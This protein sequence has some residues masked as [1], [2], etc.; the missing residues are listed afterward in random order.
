MHK[1]CTS[2]RESRQRLTGLTPRPRER[3]FSGRAQPGEAKPPALL[4]GNGAVCEHM[5]N[6]DGHRSSSPPVEIIPGLA[7]AR[8]RAHEAAGPAHVLFA[9]QV[10]AQLDGPV[11]WMR[12]NWALDRLMGDGLCH[13]MQPGRLVLARART[14]PE[15]FWTAEEALRTGLVPLV[16]IELPEVP[17]LTAVRRLNLAAETGGA[18]VAPQPAP[19]ALLLTPGAGGAPG[20]ETRWHRGPLPGWAR[21][22]Q[23]PRWRL[24]RTRAR[25]APE[26]R[27]EV[28]RT[29]GGRIVVTDLP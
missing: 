10:A 3:D 8:G 22:D 18:A 14:T 1:P 15:L 5:G 4:V 11:F 23:A 17:G 29:A 9:L 24:A 25:A 27:W 19:L 21:P 6:M 16:V 20:V 26:A 13:L 28:T 12:P 7:L 2:R